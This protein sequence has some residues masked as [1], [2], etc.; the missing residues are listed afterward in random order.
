M[1]GIGPSFGL[2][3]DILQSLQVDIHLVLIADIRLQ[4]Y[5]QVQESRVKW[6]QVQ[7]A[8]GRVTG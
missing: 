7:T 4:N 8:L 2:P 6:Q 1:C 3:D 5:P